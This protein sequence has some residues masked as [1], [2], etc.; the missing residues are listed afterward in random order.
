MAV[1]D[2]L[3]DLDMVKK[4]VKSHWILLMIAVIGILGAYTGILG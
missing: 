4:E 3:N 1:G 2:N